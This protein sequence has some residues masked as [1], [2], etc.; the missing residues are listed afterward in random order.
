LRLLNTAPT[1]HRHAK[2]PREILNRLIE[3]PPHS[4]FYIQYNA[5]VSQKS[6]KGEG[7]KKVEE[8]KG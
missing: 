1:I 4:K 7:E 5:E 2:Q 8:L 3:I 6:H